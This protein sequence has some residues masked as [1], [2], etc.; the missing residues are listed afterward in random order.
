MRGSTLVQT[1][2]QVESRIAS[3]LKTRFMLD[4]H[5]LALV[6][7][8]LDFQVWDVSM[9]AAE[10]LAEGDLR[11]ATGRPNAAGLHGAEWIEAVSD[12]QVA[13]A[14]CSENCL[15]LVNLAAGAALQRHSFSLRPRA[16]PKTDCYLR[17]DRQRG[18][19]YAVFYDSDT[20]AL[21]L[22]L[23]SLGQGDAA[24]AECI[25]RGTFQSLALVLVRRGCLLLA[26]QGF[27]SL[28]RE[29]LAFWERSPVRLL[30]K[31]DAADVLLD[32][33]VVRGSETREVLVEPE[34]LDEEPGTRTE[35][36]QTS[37]LL[38]LLNNNKLKEAGLLRFHFNLDSIAQQQ[39]VSAT[40]GSRDKASFRPLFLRH[41]S[42]AMA[43]FLQAEAML[44]DD[45]CRLLVQGWKQTCLFSLE[46][47]SADDRGPLKLL[48]A[49]PSNFAA[50][51]FIASKSK[52]VV[53]L[54]EMPASW[55]P[56]L[57]RIR[58][59]SVADEQV[60]YFW[61]MHQTGL[62][63]KLPDHAALEAIDMLL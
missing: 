41:S 1:T 31:L 58:T 46:Q 8:S 51:T 57:L 55:S 16:G 18:L 53:G 50:E 44:F 10:L 42:G 7:D 43:D 4:R 56:N 21:E 19:L 20:H 34:T 38:L 60:V 35:T 33:H 17:V 40:L 61:L 9:P 5:R 26:S 59:I 37:H 29:V 3:K 52:D 32:M 36:V 62:L 27:G 11:A 23:L 63:S 25:Y 2:R 24:K 12:S 15:V 14:N 47:S 13:V 49:L 28:D 54:V 39:L 22:F 6:S 30:L 45:D 48:S